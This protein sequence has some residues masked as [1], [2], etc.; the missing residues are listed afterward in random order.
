MINDIYYTTVVKQEAQ[1]LR[2]RAAE[3][4]LA[5]EAK[6]L[7]RQQRAHQREIDSLEHAVHGRPSWWTLLVRR[8]G[9]R[10]ATRPGTTIDAGPQQGVSRETSHDETGATTHKA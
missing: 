5:N 6:K 7:R 4:R 2:D 8:F 9:G 1:E 3:D 10:S